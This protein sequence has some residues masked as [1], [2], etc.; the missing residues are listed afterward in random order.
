MAR[1][2][3]AKSAQPAD[4]YIGARIRLR[5]RLAGMSQTELGRR[6]GVKSQQVQKYEK[7]SNRIG[8]SRL[9]RICAALEVT[10]AWLL[11]GAPGAKSRSSAAAQRIERAITAFHADHFAPELMLT[12]PRLP[13]RIKRVMVALMTALTNE[14]SSLE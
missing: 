8:A 9:L 1:K 5:R 4:A 10:P 2:T 12:F 7:G 13:V 6:V 3:A 11:E 14:K